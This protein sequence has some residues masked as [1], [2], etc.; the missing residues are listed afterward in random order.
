[1]SASEKALKFRLRGLVA[2]NVTARYPHVYALDKKR[3]VDIVICRDGKR[4]A[5][6]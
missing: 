2:R 5:I 1:M 6:Q 4:P 3:V